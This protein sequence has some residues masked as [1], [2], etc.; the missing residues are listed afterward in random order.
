MK[1]Y[2]TL[3]HKGLQVNFKEKKMFS[4]IVLFVFPF[5]SGGKIPSEMVLKFFQMSFQTNYHSPRKKNVL[6]FPPLPPT[7]DRRL[8]PN[9]VRNSR[10]CYLQSW[11]ITIGFN[12]Q[13]HTDSSLFY[14]PYKP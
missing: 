14:I 7:P 11:F 2:A 9:C 3:K 5:P 10:S 1:L 13:T 12:L 6:I 4:R 8:G